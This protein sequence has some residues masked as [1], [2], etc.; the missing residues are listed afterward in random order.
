M[1][2]G[3]KEGREGLLR[4]LLGEH[5][6]VK[7]Q[8]FS[9]AILLFK[10]QLFLK[11]IRPFGL[12]TLPT[13]MSLVLIYSLSFGCEFFFQKKILLFSIIISTDNNQILVTKF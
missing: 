3:K 13:P 12:V 10:F 1:E 11:H 7:F 5:F 8:H 6:F 2:T 4:F 9:S